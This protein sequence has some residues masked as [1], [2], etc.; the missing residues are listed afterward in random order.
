MKIIWTA[1]S[2]SHSVVAGQIRSRTGLA[3]QTQR[4]QP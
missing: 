2:V 3:A 1:R 4:G